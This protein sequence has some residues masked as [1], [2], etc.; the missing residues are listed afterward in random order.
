[1][2][3]TYNKNYVSIYEKYTE[4]LTRLNKNISIVPYPGMPEKVE[5]SVETPT[6]TPVEQ[7]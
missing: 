4:V 6:E 2:N 3:S 5:T 7:Q 1:M